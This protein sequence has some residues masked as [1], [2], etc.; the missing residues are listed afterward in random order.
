LRSCVFSA[1]LIAPLRANLISP[2]VKSGSCGRDISQM[3]ILRAVTWSMTPPRLSA[4]AMPSSISRSYRARSRAGL[5]SALA[6]RRIGTCAV[7]A[8]IDAAGSLGT[9]GHFK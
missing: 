2:R 3:A 5:P 9:W 6:S 4:A 8:G 1:W 7:G